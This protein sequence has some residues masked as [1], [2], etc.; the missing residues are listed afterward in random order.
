MADEVTQKR[1]PGNRAIIFLM[2]IILLNGLGFTVIG[3]VMP[4]IIRSYIQNPGDWERWPDGLLRS[5]LHARSLL[6][7][8]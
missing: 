3:P 2:G 1:K 4:F 7:L 8:V 6:R 5:T